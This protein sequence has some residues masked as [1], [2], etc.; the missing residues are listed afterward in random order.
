MQPNLPNEV[1]KAKNIGE[2][3]NS[4]NSQFYE[5]LSR[6]VIGYKSLITNFS[7]T[8]QQLSGPVKIVEIGAQLSSK[9]AQVLYF[10]LL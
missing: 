8:A 1:S 4:S 10:F 9:A 3:V 2:I 6:T 7:S 5:L